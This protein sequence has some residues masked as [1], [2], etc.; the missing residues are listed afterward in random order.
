MF[1]TNSRS[2]YIGSEQYSSGYF[3]IVVQ[4]P[5]D[6]KR[7]YKKEDGSDGGNVPELRAIV[8]KVGMRQSG[9]FMMGRCTLGGFRLCL[10]GSYGSDGLPLSLDQYF[11]GSGK[12][13]FRRLDFQPLQLTRCRCT[14]RSRFNPALQQPMLP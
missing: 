13:D 3:L 8:K 11:T 7:K 4:D 9:H 14:A 2:G 10:S 1:V 6:K 12:D 5:S